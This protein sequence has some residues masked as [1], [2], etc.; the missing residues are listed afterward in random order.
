MTV[1]RLWLALF[2]VGCGNTPTTG[3]NNDGGPPSGS[4][5]STTA[6]PPIAVT[7][8]D[9][10]TKTGQWENIIPPGVTNAQAIALDP[11]VSGTVWLGASP[12]VPGGLG[13]LFKS[14]DCGATWTHVNTGQNGDALDRGAMWSMAVD[15]TNQGTI[16][17]VSPGGGNGLWK[18]T[19]A[20]VDWTQLFPQNS[21]WATHVVDNTVASVTMDPTNSQ[22]LVVAPHS[23]CLAP[24]ANMCNAESTDG[25]ASWHMV[26]VNGDDWGEWT[27]PVVLNST[28]WLETLGGL[29][30]T[31]DSGQHWKSVMPSNVKYVTNAEWT[32]TPFRKSAMGYYY[33]PT[34]SPSGL[35]RSQDGAAW[36]F[37]DKSP[38]GQFNAGFAMGDGKLFLSDWQGGGYWSASESDVSTWTELPKP[39]LFY[40]NQAFGG[41]SMEYDEQHHVL[42]SANFQG[43]LFRLVQP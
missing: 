22:H 7:K 34:S 15:F 35:I 36:T 18:S 40:M 39:P 8:C 10:L 32:H 4:D 12:N 5:G 6:P 20:G 27:G 31:T 23:K 30:L 9:G 28:S 29:F 25:G 37:V 43:G 26:I 42:Y 38:G 21:E 16:Y 33:L 14:I 11:F 24:Y 19:N 13:G 17:V 41:E 2:L 3:G 1:A